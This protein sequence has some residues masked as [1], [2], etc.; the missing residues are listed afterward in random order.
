MKFT[1]PCFVRVEDAEERKSLAKFLADLD[2]YV[3]PSVTENDDEKDWVIVAEPDDDDDGI[4][5]VGLRA[6]HPKSPEFIDCGDNIKLFKALA[7]MNENDYMQWFVNENTGRWS[8][9]CG[10]DHVEDDPVISKWD[11]CARHKAT[12][13]EIINH[14][15]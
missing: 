1:T 4:G 7:A 9:C 15:K 5:Y 11:G 8:C 6:K 2:R 13:F 12:V 10:I 3:S 14:F